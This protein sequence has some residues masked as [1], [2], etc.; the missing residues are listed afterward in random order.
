MPRNRPRTLPASRRACRRCDNARSHSTPILGDSQLELMRSR[1]NPGSTTAPTTNGSVFLP[2]FSGF[3][4]RV[5]WPTPR[6]GRDLL[7]GGKF[8]NFRDLS[9][10]N[11]FPQGRRPD[12][13]LPAT[14]PPTFSGSRQA[15]CP[16]LPQ[17]FNGSSVEEILC[18]HQELLDNTDLLIGHL[19][20]SL[21]QILLRADTR[22]LRT[23]RRL[24]FILLIEQVE[25]LRVSLFF[26]PVHQGGFAIQSVWRREVSD[27]RNNRSRSILCCADA[28]QFADQGVGISF[29]IHRCQIHRFNDQQPVGRRFEMANRNWPPAISGDLSLVQLPGELP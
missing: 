27:T 25:C 10:S 1:Q 26:D 18:S 24:E 13:D 11:K 20:F 23:H 9:N 29:C 15:L 5:A 17:L 6:L 28:K 12:P 16:A 3:D 14:H 21:P 4:P 7:F 22:Q 8:L 19:I 2:R